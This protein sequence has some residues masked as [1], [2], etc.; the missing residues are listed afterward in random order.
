MLGAEHRETAVSG[1][2][3]DPRLEVDF[4]IA[5]HEVTVGR[6]EC[7]LDGVLCL[8]AGPEHVAGEGQDAPYVTFIENLESRNLSRF[9][10]RDEMI[11]VP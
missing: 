4:A 5:C 6:G 7:L 3:V 10:P 9:C 8:L 1:D 2:G 11:V